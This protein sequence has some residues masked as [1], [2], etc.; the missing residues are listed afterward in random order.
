MGV[1]AAVKLSLA[2][3]FAPQSYTQWANK[4]NFILDLF[5]LFFDKEVADDAI[6]DE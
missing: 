2:H 5:L 6:A 3:D 4:A 1:V